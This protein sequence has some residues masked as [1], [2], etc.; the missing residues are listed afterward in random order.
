MVRELQHDWVVLI[1]LSEEGCNRS[2]VGWAC[3]IQRSG[4]PRST[5]RSLSLTMISNEQR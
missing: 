3:V 2:V 4:A 1:A 5:C